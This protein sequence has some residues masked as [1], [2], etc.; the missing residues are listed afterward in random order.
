MFVIQVIYFLLSFGE[1][2]DLIFTSSFSY[3]IRDNL[4]GKTFI[5]VIMFLPTNDFLF[6]FGGV[7]G[8][9]VLV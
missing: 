3:C 5:W 4:Y 1:F 2:I 6:F 9:P 7:W 8:K